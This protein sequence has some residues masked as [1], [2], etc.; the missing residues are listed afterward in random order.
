MDLNLFKNFKIG[1]RF[2]FAI[3]AQAFNVFNHPNFGLPERFTQFLHRSPIPDP[4]TEPSAP[5]RE[6][7]RAHTAT[8][9]ALTRPRA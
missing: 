8:S 5:C 7:R 6:R 3:G 1:E 4:I 9:W 2:N